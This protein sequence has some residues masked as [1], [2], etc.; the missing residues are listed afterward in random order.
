MRCGLLSAKGGLMMGTKK[1]GAFSSP[2]KKA[3]IIIAPE[4]QM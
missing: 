4:K 3:I 1:V 2:H